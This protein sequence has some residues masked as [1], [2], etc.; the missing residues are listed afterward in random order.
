MSTERS[1]AAQATFS[2]AYIERWAVEYLRPDVNRKLRSRGCAFETFLM[3]PEEIL[4]A[5]EQPARLNV[6]PGLLAAQRAVQARLDA[7]SAMDE[8]T[9]CAVRR[10]GRNARCANGTWIEPLHHRSYP[11]NPNRKI[12]LEA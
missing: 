1:F 11:R 5:I 9:D 12:L 10:F 2:D 7:L 6:L 4:A 8:L 3:A